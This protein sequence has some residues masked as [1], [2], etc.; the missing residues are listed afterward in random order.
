MRA[1]ISSEQF[2]QCFPM[3]FCIQPAMGLALCQVVLIFAILKVVCKKKKKVEEGGCRNIMIDLPK[4]IQG[5]V[6]G[7]LSNSGNDHLYLLRSITFLFL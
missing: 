5:S 2:C 1:F 3:N 4:A 6:Y 7:I